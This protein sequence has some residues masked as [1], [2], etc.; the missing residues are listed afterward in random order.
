MDPSEKQKPS[1]LGGL[2]NWLERL[3]E[4]FYPQTRTEYYLFWI[5]I[6]LIFRH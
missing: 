2:A 5:L 3:E 6:V 4:K 1:L